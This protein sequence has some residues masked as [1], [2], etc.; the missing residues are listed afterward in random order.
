V[1]FRL[2][3]GTRQLIQ[4]RERLPAAFEMICHTVQV[5]FEILHHTVQVKFEAAINWGTV[6]KICIQNEQACHR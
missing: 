1:A 4:N 6:S 5:K 3:T 2:A